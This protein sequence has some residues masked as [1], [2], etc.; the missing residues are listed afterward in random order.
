MVLTEAGPDSGSSGP[1]PGPSV[2]ANSSVN[3]NLQ[4]AGPCL[5]PA[6]GWMHRKREHTAIGLA[7]I[8][9]A[10][11]EQGVWMPRRTL[12]TLSLRPVAPRGGA[13]T[14]RGPAR[15]GSTLLA[16]SGAGGL[17]CSPS[18]ARLQQRE[19]RVDHG[20]GEGDEGCWSGCRGWC[21]TP[22]GIQG[23]AP[24]TCHR[25]S[26]LLPLPR[27]LGSLVALPCGLR[28][29][30]SWCGHTGFRSD[31]GF[32]SAALSNLAPGETGSPVRC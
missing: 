23:F 22:R 15:M 4:S 17:T 21:R 29:G 27:L 16:G 12:P 20:S 25:V 3:C 9:S 24:T 26:A 7:G 10:P 2:P 31:T 19:R 18:P 28:L 14:A 5:P 13:Q 8:A 6:Q 11:S 1:T 30:T 32:C